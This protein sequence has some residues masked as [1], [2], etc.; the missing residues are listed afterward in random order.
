MGQGWETKTQMA[1]LGGTG[2]RSLEAKAPAFAFS[3]GPS[4][5]RLFLFALQVSFFTE[6]PSIPR[7][8][9]LG[10]CPRLETTPDPKTGPPLFHKALPQS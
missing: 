3:K 6:V 7:C 10:L 4:A 8:R 2:V 1:R 9:I 5:L